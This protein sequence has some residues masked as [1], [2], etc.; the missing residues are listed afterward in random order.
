M[1]SRRAAD[2]D[3]AVAVGEHAHDVLPLGAR[4]RRRLLEARLL[5]LLLEARRISRN[6]I[7][8]NTRCRRPRA[9][10]RP[11]QRPRGSR[12]TARSAG[13]A[14]VLELANQVDARRLAEPEVDDREIEVVRE[15]A[16]RAPRPASIAAMHSA[17]STAARFQEPRIRSSSS[18]TRTFCSDTSVSSSH[19][20]YSETKTRPHRV[21]TC[22]VVRIEP[23]AAK[24]CT[25]C[26]CDGDDPTTVAHVDPTVRL[27]REAAMQHDTADSSCAVARS[28]GARRRS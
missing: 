18:T 16:S 5:G 9:P 20:R 7:G 3:V 26:S 12:C 14:V 17:L 27:L 8:L 19:A 11:W 23:V 6:V 22:R 21:T 15:C 28:A 13:R 24:R 10:R 25:H 1:P 2:R 4:E